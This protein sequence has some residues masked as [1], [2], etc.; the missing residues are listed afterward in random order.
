MGIISFARLCS[1]Q[2][3]F[4]NIK[5]SSFSFTRID[6]VF[7][8]PIYIYIYIYIYYME[9]GNVLPISIVSTKIILLFLVYLGDDSSA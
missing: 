3:S 9:G 7:P 4:A 8:D 2:N 6:P 1:L 5:G